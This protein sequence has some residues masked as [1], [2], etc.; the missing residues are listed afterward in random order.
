[1]RHVQ[2]NKLAAAMMA[3]GTPRSAAEA[4]FFFLRILRARLPG[5]GDLQQGLPVPPAHLVRDA[6]AIRRVFPEFF[7]LPQP[8]L[9]SPCNK[10]TPVFGTL[11]SN[12]FVMQGCVEPMDP[13]TT[14]TAACRGGLVAVFFRRR[15]PSICRGM[16]EVGATSRRPRRQ[17]T[18]PGHGRNVSRAGRQER[19]QALRPTRELTDH[20]RGYS[21][22]CME[23]T[24]APRVS[25]V[26]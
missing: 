12:N 15:L 14:F 19:C 5:V 7:R 10:A 21:C 22:A 20:R 16:R 23:P 2:K 8:G 13:D 3:L 18:S 11:F 25:Q 9:L 6:D 17:G 24:R 26:S 4:P 1:V